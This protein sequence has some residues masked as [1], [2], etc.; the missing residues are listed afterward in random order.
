MPYRLATP[1]YLFDFP[2]LADF[3]VLRKRFYGAAKIFFI[4]F[5]IFIRL[6]AF[7]RICFSRTIGIRGEPHMFLKDLIG[8]KVL[9]HDGKIL[10]Y[11]RCA[12]FSAGFK[13]IT[14]LLCA[15]EEEEDFFL[16]LSPKQPI[17]DALVMPR[18]KSAKI[19][20]MPYSPLLRQ[21]YSAQG[22]F[23]G[24]VTDVRLEYLS[25][26]AL[27]IDGN[28]YPAGRVKAFGD[29]GKQSAPRRSPR[30]DAAP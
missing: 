14:A 2:I 1:Q 15:D 6:F 19:T 3:P 28:E 22:K 24:R 12:L 20:G 18:R 27:L 26:A 13:R 11:T 29:C 21:A 10:G 23:L 4:F 30:Q 7:S 8:K 16:P 5:D 9:S 25:V 17:D